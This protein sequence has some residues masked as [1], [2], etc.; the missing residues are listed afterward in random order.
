MPIEI[1]GAD[2]ATVGPIR[3]ALKA[4][5]KH[6]PTFTGTPA[7][8]TADASTNNTQLATTAFVHNAVAAAGAGVTTFIA[9]TDVP[10]T[11][12]GQAGRFVAVNAGAT[13]LEFVD[14]PGGGGAADF[15]DL[16]DV[17][18]AYTGQA[19]KMLF[20]R[21]TEDGL[22]F[23]DAPAGS[24][25]DTF[26]ELTD[27]PANYIG[28]AGKMVVVKATED[29]L[30]FDDVPAGGGGLANFT[31]GVSTAAPNATVPVVSLTATDAAT[32]AD[33]ALIAKGTGATLAQ[34]PTGSSSGGNKRGDYAVDFSR[35][36]RNAATQVASGL[37]SFIGSG[38]R[39]TASG[40]FSAVVA[41]QLCTASGTQSFV[42]GGSGNSATGDYSTVPAGLSNTASGS[43]S[44][45]IGSSC[46]ASGEVSLAMGQYASTRGLYGM[47]AHGASRFSIMGDA[48]KGEYVLRRQT[49][50]ATATELTLDGGAPAAGKRI[51]LPINHAYKFRGQIV[52]RSTAGDVKSWEI[53]G[54]IKQ[55]LTAAS[56]AL[57]GAA[58]VTVKDEDAGAAMWALSVD[59]DTTNGSLR[60][61]GTG[62]A[63]TTIRWVAEVTT[64]EVG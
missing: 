55:G 12:T 32:N 5:A 44:M 49:A 50:D 46:T 63:A 58:T 10:A 52:A 51:A 33:A 1:N 53:N 15:T 16:G 19:G 57:V 28:H 18:A 40:T 7:A 34:I 60:I 26:I 54:T 37:A 31:E 29:G 23:G 20:V 11:Y 45:A 17:P 13:A 59:A 22:E 8:P 2:E 43:S 39:N 27:V 24:G 41:G 35:Y 36:N 38:T 47:Q 64:V 42:G 14:P 4:A 3:E 25:V 61:Q 62:A 21:A 9:L 48:Q 6:S 56:T 30:E